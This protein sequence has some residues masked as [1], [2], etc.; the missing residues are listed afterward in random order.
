MPELNPRAVPGNN[1]DA[2]D[3]AKQE[4]ERLRSDY[5]LLETT[6]VELEDEARPLVE[7]ENGNPKD[8]A[9]IIT[10]PEVKGRVATLIKR[11]RDTATRANSFR[12]AEKQPHF[13]RG[14]GVDMFFFGL[15]DR[16]SKRDRKN[17]DGMG[18]TLQ[19]ALD[20]YDN[21]ILLE[22]QARRRRAAEEAQREADRL[23]REEV[24][25]LRV[26]EETRLAAERARKPETTAAKQEIANTAEVL[27]TEATI[28]AAL[29]T[30]KAE[31]LHVQ[32]LARPADIMRS[33]GDDGTLSTMKREGYAEIADARLL[34]KEALWPFISINEKEK[35][36]RAWAKSTGHTQEMTGA[37]I[38]FRNKSVVR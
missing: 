4:S 7:D 9:D 18:D 13:R 1:T 5:G 20:E 16:L 3:Y 2:P 23:R 30:N 31:D 21:R 14:Q 19:R 15:I 34:D 26:A 35:A 38:G 37:K 24:E 27:A 10:D 32:T 17:R 8:P 36:L 22:E 33:R 12:E 29:A 6:V 25:R 11:M 28:D